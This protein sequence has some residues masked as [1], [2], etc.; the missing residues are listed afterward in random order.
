MTPC[1][2]ACGACGPTGEELVREGV[3]GEVGDVPAELAVQDLHIG[4]Q[5]PQHACMHTHA[6]MYTSTDKFHCSNKVMRQCGCGGVRALTSRAVKI[7]CGGRG[8]LT[9]LSLSRSETHAC[10]LEKSV[11]GWLVLVP[12]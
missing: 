4:Q 1:S 7:T 8:A 11:G 6:N 2:P 9:E 5:R 3:L 12:T 10:N